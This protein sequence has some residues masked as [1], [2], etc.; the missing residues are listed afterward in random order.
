MLMDGTVTCGLSRLIPLLQLQP[1]FSR[2][3]SWLPY[4]VFPLVPSPGFSCSEECFGSKPTR[5]IRPGVRA[6]FRDGWRDSGPFPEEEHRFYVENISNQ[7]WKS[8]VPYLKLLT[9]AQMQ[10]I[11][12]LQDLEGSTFFPIPLGQKS[13]KPIKSFTVIWAPYF[14]K[15]GDLEFKGK[16]WSYLLLIWLRWLHQIRFIYKENNAINVLAAQI[17]MKTSQILL[18]SPI[19]CNS[20]NLTEP[21]PYL[22]TCN[23]PKLN[24]WSWWKRFR[25]VFLCVKRTQRR[26]SE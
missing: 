16:V 11:C 3:A 6:G 20:V 19:K 22:R 13:L 2:A 4:S 12:S 8:S 17:F 23:P 24:L 14:L 5:R 1:W 25:G 9:T 7:T 18:S 10:D 21:N 26:C 15:P